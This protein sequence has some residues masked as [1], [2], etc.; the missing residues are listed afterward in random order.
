MDENSKISSVDSYKLGD[1]ISCI[2]RTNDELFSA[3][4]PFFIDGLNKGNKCIY[5]L[6]EQS[7]DEVIKAFTDSGV[8]LLPY[9]LKKDF[10][11]ASHKDIYFKNNNFNIKNVTSNLV[12]EESKAMEQGYTGLRVAGSAWSIINESPILSDFVEY[13]KLVNEF[14]ES[15][16]I[17]AMCLYKESLFENKALI[18]TIYS[19]PLIYL[20]DKLIENNYY[21]SLDTGFSK[22]SFEEIK[23]SLESSIK[24][25]SRLV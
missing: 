10:I 3:I 14:L 12:A 8:D 17:T 13:E 9:I 20:Y 21:N 6:G 16:F 7:Q 24:S 25:S 23:R 5:I 4:I 2:Y 22:L 18:D 19:H 15:S 11:F 1:H